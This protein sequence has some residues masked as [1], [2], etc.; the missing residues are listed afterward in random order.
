MNDDENKNP[1]ALTYGIT[2]N[3]PAT[4]HP[5]DVDTWKAEVSP[6]FKHYFKERYDVVV[7]DYEKLVREYSINKMLYES[8]ISFK[9]NIGD[10]YYLYKKQ[11]GSAFI[12][13]VNPAQAFWGGYVGTF[14]LNAQYAWE[15]VL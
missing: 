15:E 14:K 1:N 10:T 11:N 3:A 4:I 9:P 13:L 8:S 7:Q 2:P 5:V 6:T 12:S